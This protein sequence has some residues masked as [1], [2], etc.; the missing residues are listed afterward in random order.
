MKKWLCLTL[1]FVMLLGLVACGESGAGDTEK[2]EFQV[3]FGKVDI[4]P[5]EPIHLASY[6]DA[7][8]RISEGAMHPLYSICIVMKDADGNTMI[9]ITTDL[10]QGG[11]TI[12][13]ELRPMITEKY[14]VQADHITIG[15][16][17]NHNAPDYGY[18]DD[19]DQK[20]KDVYKNGC[21]D[22]IQ[23][24]MDDLAPAT[25]QIGRTETE[26]VTFVR[27]YLLEN[28]E[29]TGDNFNMDYTSPI[30]AHESEADEEIQLVR[31]VRE[32]DKK[33]IVM[34][35]WQA[36][37]AKHG[38]TNYLSADYP[39]A[40]RDKVEAEL[41]VH[42][43]FYQGACGNLNPSSRIHGEAAVD[44]GG[45]QK[46]VAVGELVADYVIKALNTEGVMKQINTGKINA[47]QDKFIGQD[48]FD[49]TNTITCGDLSFVT[50]PVEFFDSLG[51]QIKDET[52]YEMTVL[53]GFHCGNGQYL[54]TYDAYLH[55][56]YEP[57]NS[58][59]RAGEGE[60]FVEYY[61]NSLNEMYKAEN[62]Q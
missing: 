10:S 41:G 4:T 1:A 32:G 47:K 40:L 53:M 60:K 12:M 11:H 30:K 14:G 54:A 46:A 33:D 17:H 9:M 56:G 18:N 45:Y 6:G 2:G 31:Y 23:M 16:T 43:V 51:K 58:R 25:V 52:P 28:G 8:T 26:N 7:D 35:N 24:A 19:Y 5:A 13:N 44:G 57:R 20:W 15:G 59:Y 49:E 21:M 29:Y 36:H 37:A 42:C 48:S 50:L 55:G 27:R 39:G 61:L 62:P 38:H 3:G 34:V 22:A